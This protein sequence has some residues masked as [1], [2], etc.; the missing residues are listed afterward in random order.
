MINYRNP[1]PDVSMGVKWIQYTAE[2]QDFLEIGNEFVV[3]NAPDAEAI[4]FWE[5]LM[6]QYGQKPY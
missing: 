5:N 4:Q 3:G 1:T 2:D 6:R